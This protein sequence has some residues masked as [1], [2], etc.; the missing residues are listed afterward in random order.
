MIH[1]LY[2]SWKQPVGYLFTSGVMNAY[3]FECKLK[4]CIDSI[5]DYGIILKLVVSGQ[6]PINRDCT[7]NVI[8]TIDKPY[9]I[10]K[11]NTIFFMYDFPHI[12]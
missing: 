2:G 7:N 10:Y 6:G 8:T 11:G 5:I 3:T 12:L 1:S 4:D 9:F